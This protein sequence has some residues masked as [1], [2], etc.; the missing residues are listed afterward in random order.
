M[1]LFVKIKNFK[2]ITL[3][4]IIL[5]SFIRLRVAIMTDPIF[6]FYDSPAYFN[7][8][9]FPT[10][11]L[12]GITLIYGILE[13]HKVITIFQ[14][15]FGIFA[16]IL[17]WFSLSK[18]IRRDFEKLIFTII[19]YFLFISSIII[20]HDS[21]LLSESLSISSMQIFIGAFVLNLNSN[22]NS[23]KGI[24]VFI[25]SLIFFVS[26][27]NSHSLVTP[28]LIPI[29]IFVI[30]KLTKS[31]VLYKFINSILA[32]S[33]V[34]FF[35]LAGQS[36]KDFETLVTNAIINN[37]LWENNDWRRQVIESGYS[38]E[39]HMIWLNSKN[40]N[41][42]SPPDQTVADTM[43]FKSWW[44]QGG[45]SFLINFGIHN[46]TYSFLGPI[47]LPL[48]DLNQNY[49]KTLL[50]GW[51]QGTDYSRIYPEFK[52]INLIRTIF[53]PDEPEKAYLFLSIIFILIGLSL[54]SDYMN[55]NRYN[56][57]ILSTFIILI[58][59]LSFPSWWF[60]SKPG[61]MARH[62]LESAIMW[63]VAG[64]LAVVFLLAELRNKLTKSI[65]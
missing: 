29:L 43:E 8:T 13:T 32:V 42:G 47:F 56:V 58:F 28:F 9:F 37:R 55:G 1:E 39:L 38:E 21:V 61:D 31:Q 49:K 50:S 46:P 51:S 60:G 6:D 4:I 64:C 3:M 44:N 34:T 53:W 40:F 62:N 26:T 23:N 2:M 33:S 30:F 27:K 10:I 22:F 48:I 41:L 52:N 36:T 5:Y 16:T 14:S 18:I 7:L 45:D 54:I 65:K 20:E 63:R 57:L 12:Q 17:L 59:M 15:M 24:L 25:I 35:F 19:Y 11:R